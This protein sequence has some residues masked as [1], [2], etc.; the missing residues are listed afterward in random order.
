MK[1]I[2]ALF[3]AL[4]AAFS[5]ID[6]S[7]TP[8]ETEAKFNVY[9]PSEMAIGDTFSYEVTGTTEATVW[10]SSNESVATVTTT[11]TVTAIAEGTVTLTVAYASNT[12]SNKKI[13]LTVVQPSALRKITVAE[14]AADIAI[15]E[16][17]HIIANAVN[18]S[19]S[20]LQ[21]ESSNT[22][23]VTVD[24]SGTVTAVAKGSAT[25]TIKLQ[26]DVV[27]GVANPLSTRVTI[28]VVDAKPVITVAKESATIKK[29]ETYQ[30][31]ASVQNTTEAL[32]YESSDAAIATVDA[33]G[34]VTAVAD[35]TATM[36]LSVGS[37]KAT[38]S[39]TVVDSLISCN[40][41]EK[42]EV[43]AKFTLE[44]TDASDENAEFSY[45]SSSTSLAKVSAS[46]VITAKAEGTVTITITN[47]NNDNT[48][49]VEI[50]LYYTNPTEIQLGNL[51][52]DTV[53]T[54][55]NLYFTATVL[56]SG[57]KQDV[58]WTSSDDSIVDVDAGNITIYGDGTVTITATA[59]ADP[60][61]ST[62]YELVINYDI[63]QIINDAYLSVPYVNT[64]TTFGSTNIQQDVLGSVFLFTL[65]DYTSDWHTKNYTVENIVPAGSSNRPGTIKS[66]TEFILVHDTANNATGAT[67]KANANYVYNGGGGTSWHYTS[68]SDGVYHQI[69]DNEVAYHAGD[70][71]G[72]KWS[73]HYSGVLATTHKKPTVT[74]SSDGYYELNGQ[75]TV[76][77]APTK[78]GQICKTSDINDA[79]IFTEIGSD[80]YWYIGETWYST[81]YGYIAN[82]G[83]NNNSIGIETCVNPDG[84]LYT[85][86]T[87]TAKLV[88]RLMI[89]NNL[90]I[91]RVVP[92]H[93]FSGKDCPMTMRH[94]GYWATFK[95]MVWFEYLMETRLYSQGY[96]IEIS[97]SNTKLVNNHGR[98][99]TI[100]T[101]ASAVKVTVTL[102]APDG[103]TSSKQYT[104]T[105]RK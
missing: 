43:G 92:H 21:Y 36:T 86:W 32:A 61:I 71:T 54:T 25:I 75:K 100:P 89:I 97:S 84:D 13:T 39:I 26:E 76:V 99:V 51:P 15:G 33:N 74:I 27:N 79:G 60:K 82:H 53:Y 31:E 81:T 73:T 48:L 78:N 35:G 91:D 87:Y 44:A 9:G 34:L 2:L 18:C 88:A 22:S 16:T 1:K 62:S 55:S 10:S 80:G 45:T 46:G 57:A 104:P 69:P 98:I 50:E 8:K 94:A 47:I 6:C 52:T 11:G 59:V 28:N 63:W 29:G 14:E 24:A 38:V 7:K 37:V 42:L 64:V 40:A 95:K 90:S 102:T 68:G 56:P 41:P 93:F 30:I 12:N 23:V 77:L 20:S 72:V 105:I 85:T 103:T 58:V 67:A 5:L 19:S 65:D 3:V 4:C 17:Y 49:D 96:S 83:G 101:V 66:S 70:G